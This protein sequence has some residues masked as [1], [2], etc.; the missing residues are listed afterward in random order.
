G[1]D[2]PSGNSGRKPTHL[3]YDG[4]SGG[5]GKFRFLVKDSITSDVTE[6]DEI[7]D[8][9]LHH[10]VAHSATGVFEPEAQIYVD[11]LTILNTSIMP[12]PRRDI[13]VNVN[14]N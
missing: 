7:F 14:D 1:S 2:G 4:R 3:L 12:T 10:V 11:T 13:C 6:Y 5:S 9:R 8:I